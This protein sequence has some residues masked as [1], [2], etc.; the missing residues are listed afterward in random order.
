MK[1]LLEIR[2]KVAIKKRKTTI[3]NEL[4]T[5]ISFKLKYKNIN[6]AYFVID[7]IASFKNNGGKQN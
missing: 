5:W 1:K 3:L 2:K 6:M 4:T 7:C